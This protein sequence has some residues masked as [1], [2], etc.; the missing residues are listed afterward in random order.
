[1]KKRITLI[2]VVFDSANY[3]IIAI[4]T[5]LCV[6]PFYYIFINTI[7]D[8]RLATLGKVVFYPLG[9]QFGNYIQIMKIPG[10][11]QATFVSL[12]RTVLGTIATLFG[13]SFLGYATSK[14]EMWKRK[15]WYRYIVFTMYLNAG[16]IPWFVTMKMI[17]M[18]DNFLAYILPSLVTPFNV[19]LFKTYIEQIPASLEES[20]QIDGAGYLMRFVRI[21]L[22]LCIPIIATIAIFSSVGQWNSFGD[23]LFLMRK[24][25][26]FTLQF[27]LYQYLSEANNLAAYLRNASTSTIL[28]P[29]KMLTP[30]SIRM[31]I[32]MVVVLPILF[33]YPFFQRYFVKGIMIGA[34]KG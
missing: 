23:T 6:F 33:V 12:G 25:S 20:A 34:V 11:G 3:F 19:I 21:I 1:M 4:F 22:P 16:I 17:G 31:T 8:N 29:E 24:P 30:T 32:S 18:V 14:K 7:S 9:I 15:L 13:S 10:L 26:L 28:H 5:L 27:I 2:N